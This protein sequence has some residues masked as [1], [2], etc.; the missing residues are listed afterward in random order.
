ML[1]QAPYPSHESMYRT[2]RDFLTDWTEE[3]E[4]TLKV[5]R[6]LTEESLEQRV[7]PGG[8]T[9]GRLA[10]HI[11]LTVPEMMQEAG[12]EVAGPKEDAPRPPL[13]ELIREYASSAR[14]LSDALAERWTDAMLS[15]TVPMYGEEW[16][17]G[18]VLSALLRHQTH[19]RG[20][21]TVLM[22]Q[23]GLKV[24]GVYGPAREEWAQY[25]VPPQE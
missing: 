15:E 25:G 24:P 1:E 10:W 3:S 5:F 9:L 13:R 16:T 12:L 14:A 17:R 7:G 6:A 2:I 11:V 18:K 23:A 8:R 4:S 20:Q 21:M 22:R 19:H